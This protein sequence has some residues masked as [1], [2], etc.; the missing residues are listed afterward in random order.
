MVRVVAFGVVGVHGVRH[1]GGD[2]EGAREGPVEVLG[3]AA[4]RGDGPAEHPLQ[5][6]PWAPDWEPL[7]T[8]SWSKAA[9][10]G[11]WAGGRA[12]VAAETSAVTPACTEIWLSRRGETRNSSSA[13][14]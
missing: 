10:T 2:A 3:A 9:S 7:P 6:G 8:S 1:V 5:Q 13:P 4:A 14:R 12:A 11:M